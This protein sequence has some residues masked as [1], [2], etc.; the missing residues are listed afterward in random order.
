MKTPRHE[1][2]WYE[3]RLINNKKPSPITEEERTVLTDENRRLI[4]E[5]A[6][7]LEWGVK[8]GFIKYPPRSEFPKWIPRPTNK[9]PG[10]STEP[11]PLS[12]LNSSETLNSVWP[13]SEAL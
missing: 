12:S 3:S 2:P 8:H 1:Q 10:S 9:Q 13:S 6:K 11:T 7:V 5:S 4:E